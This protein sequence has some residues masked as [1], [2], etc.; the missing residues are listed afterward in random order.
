MKLT[1]ILV[2]LV[3]TLTNSAVVS[4]VPMEETLMPSGTPVLIR[5]ATLSAVTPTPNTHRASQTVTVGEPI[6][7]PRE[8]RNAGD[9]ASKETLPRP[10]APG[11]QYH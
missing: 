4:Q 10:G 5:G 3:A 6:S 2:A 8:Y 7:V 1:I 11:R 9:T